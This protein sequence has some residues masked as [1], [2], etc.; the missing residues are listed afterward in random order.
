MTVLMS[1]NNSFCQLNWI[2]FAVGLSLVLRAFGDHYI[3]NVRRFRSIAAMNIRDAVWCVRK[4]WILLSE[5]GTFR[6]VVCHYYSHSLLFQQCPSFSFPL[7]CFFSVLFMVPSI[8]HCWKQSIIHST[9]M[10]CCQVDHTSIAVL[11]G[12]CGKSMCC[13][14]AGVPQFQCL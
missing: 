12:L 6:H 5:Q 14:S 11:T 8:L 9:V 4:S 10:Q 1:V 3:T 13:F 7:F 2:S